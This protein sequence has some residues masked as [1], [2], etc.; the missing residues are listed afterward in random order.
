MKKFMESVHHFV[1]DWAVNILIVVFAT[2]TLAQPFIVPTA[3][4][5]STVRVGD[6]MIVDKLAYSPSDGFS[7][8]L[9]P[10]AEPKRGDV[11]VFR[12]PIDINQNYVKAL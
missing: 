9:L 6:H 11:V 4:M 10:Y 1:T 7:K 12:R 2:T 8:H 3:S 5:E